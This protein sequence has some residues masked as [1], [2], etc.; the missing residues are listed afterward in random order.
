MKKYIVIL[1]LVATCSYTSFSQECQ[2]LTDPFT[3]ESLIQ[4]E[5]R[6]GGNR[7]L[8][9]ESRNG[10]ATVEMKFG[11]VGAVEFTIPK[12]SEVLMK[13]EN[14]DVI[15]LI[16]LL[17]AKSAISNATI[18][19]NNSLTFSGYSFQLNSLSS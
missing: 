11:E 1:S 6:S 7:T 14:G 3:N 15:K 4:F 5:W 17:E 10:K 2:K 16:T 18:D 12:G 9:Y 8:L 13:L 19:A